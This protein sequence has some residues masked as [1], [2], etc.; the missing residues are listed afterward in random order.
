MKIERPRES[1]ARAERNAAS[2]RELIARQSALVL[3]LGQ[4]GSD[5]AAAESVLRTLQDSHRLQEDFVVTYRGV[6]SS[7][8]GRRKERQESLRAR[9]PQQCW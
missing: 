7:C 2:G 3:N 4:N 6:Q 5:T 8:T 9:S 1:L